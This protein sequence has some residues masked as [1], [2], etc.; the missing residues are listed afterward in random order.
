MG[1]RQQHVDTVYG[2][3][4]GQDA[5]HAGTKKAYHLI[6]LRRHPDKNANIPEGEKAVHEAITKRANSA[7]EALGHP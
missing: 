3:G 7:W 4:Y 6:V 5:S 1:Y 2:F